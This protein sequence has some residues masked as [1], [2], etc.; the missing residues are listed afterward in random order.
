MGP[1]KVT[2][3]FSLS[4][5]DLDVKKYSSHMEIKIQITK[6]SDFISIVFTNVKAHISNFILIN[7]IYKIRREKNKF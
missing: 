7:I 2:T 4:L 1:W 5:V 3:T 6:M